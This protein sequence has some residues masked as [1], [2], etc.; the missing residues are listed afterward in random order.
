MRKIFARIFHKKFAKFFAKNFRENFSQK[1]FVFEIPD[2][3]GFALTEKMRKAGAALSKKLNKLQEKS[4]SIDGREST[5][6]IAEG[7]AL[8]NYQ[9]LK[10]KF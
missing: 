1:I 2:G 8:S 10:C 3:E 6:A 7:L 5:L 9:F 4:I